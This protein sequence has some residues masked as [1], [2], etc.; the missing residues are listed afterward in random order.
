M[1]ENVALVTENRAAQLYQRLLD[2]WE[3]INDKLAE[4]LHPAVYTVVILLIQLFAQIFYGGREFIKGLNPK[5]FGKS[6][7]GD[8]VLITGGGSGIGRLIAQ[9]LARLGAVIVTVDVNTQGNNETVNSIVEAGYKAHG[10]TCDLTKKTQID[11]VSA[12][13]KAE[14]GDVSILINNAGV[15]NGK[16]LLELTEAQIH[17]TF[18]VNVMAHFWTIRNFLPDMIARKKGHIVTVASLAGHGG[19]NKLVDYC[20][21][22]FANVGFDESL[23]TELYVQGL[24]DHIQTTCICPYYITTGMFQGVS[25]KI[26]PLLKPDFVAEEVVNAILINKQMVLLPWWSVLLALLK[27]TFP[28]RGFLHVAKT[29]GFNS[30][31]DEFVGRQKKA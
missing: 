31:M 2:M 6:V 19:T 1:E 21:S 23:R 30:S 12:K 3:A 10:Y 4:S 8:V 16:S 22:K 7:R 18:D 14:V 24:Q 17:R 29:F 15:V 27:Y 20:A 28:S 25:S 9:K 5:F 13:I 11:D 26:I